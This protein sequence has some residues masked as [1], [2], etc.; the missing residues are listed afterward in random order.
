MFAVIIF[1]TFAHRFKHQNQ[2][3]VIIMVIPK[4][5]RA[6]GLVPEFNNVGALAVA[7][8]IC[9]K[10]NLLHNFDFV[11]RNR[12]ISFLRLPFRPLP[13]KFIRKRP[14]GRA[15]N[16]DHKRHFVF[17]H[18]GK[19]LVGNRPVKQPGRLMRRR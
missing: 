18:C 2:H 19:Y 14:F 8:K 7:F 6:S 17:G 12:Y 4:R 3:I 15:E 5:R 13:L 16:I 1:H 11:R 9:V 10:K